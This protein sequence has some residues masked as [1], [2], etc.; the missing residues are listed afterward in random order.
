MSP[1]VACG[2]GN[3]LRTPEG[4]AG[5][6]VTCP[7][8]G[9]VMRLPPPAGGS[10][11]GARPATAPATAAPRMWVLGS[12]FRPTRT[13][14]GL[15][16]ETLVLVK[17]FPADRCERVQAEFERRGGGLGALAPGA[18]TVH[19]DEITAVSKRE[20]P[21]QV[22]LEVCYARDGR[23]APPSDADRGP[24]GRAGPVR[25]AGAA[26]GAGLELPRVTV[27][28]AALGMDTV[29]VRDLP[30]RGA[31]R[32]HADR[33]PPRLPLCRGPLAASAGRGRRVVLARRPVRVPQNAQ[34]PGYRP[35][36]PARPSR[37][38]HRP[39]RLRRCWLG[40]GGPGV[41][42]VRVDD[43]RGR[44]RDPADAEM[45]RTGVGTAS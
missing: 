41:G 15:T 26:T 8:C 28:P 36:R 17:D 42:L 12:E 16:P 14:V 35:G 37:L 5:R 44:N 30:D 9:Q 1:A 40:P 4:L 11:G 10:G 32:F 29:R 7:A 21:F 45:S 43:G 20:G 3:R 33:F 18:T 24:E 13:L 22:G 25:V 34:R 27:P 38:H 31:R 6:R 39:D 23:P 2:C 19:M